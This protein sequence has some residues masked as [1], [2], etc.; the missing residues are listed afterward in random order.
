MIF[1]WI[2]SPFGE[3]HTD[4]SWSSSGSEH[5]GVA[6]SI[7]WRL[8]EEK[9]NIWNGGD[10]SSAEGVSWIRMFGLLKKDDKI[11]NQV[12][13]DFLEYIKTIVV[14]RCDNLQKLLFDV[15]TIINGI[16]IKQE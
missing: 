16:Y 11:I 3:S 15:R 10:Q 13:Y 8:Y 1:S 5:A 14:R 6:F 2:R 9:Y 12:S 4:A 7:S